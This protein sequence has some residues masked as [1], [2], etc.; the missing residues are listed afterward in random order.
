LETIPIFFISVDD[1]IR[2]IMPPLE[3][4]RETQ[5]KLSLTAL[6]PKSVKSNGDVSDR[7]SHRLRGRIKITDP[8]IIEE[9]AESDLRE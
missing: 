4:P 1:D 5:E 2:I 6:K 7:P 3:I 9:I 8:A